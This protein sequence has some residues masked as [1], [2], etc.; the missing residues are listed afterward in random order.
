M[1]YEIVNVV[2][3]EI[4]LFYLVF[5]GLLAA[6]WAFHLFVATTNLPDLEEGPK[7]SD[8][9]THRGPGNLNP[10]FTFLFSA[11]IGFLL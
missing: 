7:Y 1:M 3:A 9:L 6:W 4:G 2:L 5:Y 10:L 11:N 8:Y